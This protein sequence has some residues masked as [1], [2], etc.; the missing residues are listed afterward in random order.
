MILIITTFKH[1]NRLNEILWHFTTG[2]ELVRAGILPKLVGT[3]IYVP[4]MPE[5]FFPTSSESMKTI[6]AN[7]FSGCAT[8]SR[9]W[10]FFMHE[11][12]T[13]NRQLRLSWTD[14]ASGCNEIYSGTALVPYDT[15]VLVGFSLSKAK[16]RASIVMNDQ[17]VVDTQ[18]GIGNY[19]RQGR[20]MQIQQAALAD[21]VLSDSKKLLL[22]AHVLARPEEIAQAHGF[23][24]FMGDV[25]IFR[26]SPDGSTLVNLLSCSSQDAATGT[27]GADVLSGSA[28]TCGSQAAVSVMVQFQQGSESINSITGTRLQPHL[29]TRGTMGEGQP[30][31]VPIVAFA[32]KVLHPLLQKPPADSIVTLPGTTLD[33]N[34]CDSQKKSTIARG[35]E[36]LLRFSESDLAN[37]QA[38]ADAWASEVRAAMQFTWKGYRT[39]GWAWNF[40][41]KAWGHD[42]VMPASGRIKAPSVCPHGFQI[43]TGVMGGVLGNRGTRAITMLDGLSTLWVMGLEEEFNDAVE[44]LER[45][46]LPTADKHGQH[47]LFEINIRAFA[48]LLSAYSL[49]GKQVFLDTAKRLGEKLLKAFDTPSGMP[50]STIDIGTGEA[51][52]HSWNQNAVLAE[53]TTL[54]VEFRFITQVTGDRRW[55]GAAD[56]AMDVVLKAAGNRGLL[57]FEG[58]SPSGA[59]SQRLFR[60]I[61][62]GRFRHDSV[63]HALVNPQEILAR[64]P[65]AVTMEI[66]EN[67]WHI[68]GAVLTAILKICSLIAVG[69]HLERK[70][71]LN[72]EKRKC[73]SALAMDVCLPCLLFTD[74]LPEANFSL[75]MEGWQLLLWPFAYAS[76]SAL[77]GMLCCL[78]IGIPSQH[79]GAAAACAAFPNV[80]GFP[81]SVISALGSA[82]PK[83]PA[84][85]SPMV[86]L[87]IIQLTDGLLKYTLGPAVFRRDR[88]MRPS[89]SDLPL[90]GSL[91]S[92]E[93]DGSSRR[94]EAKDLDAAIEP[95]EQNCPNGALVAQKTTDFGLTMDQVH[96]VEPDWSRFDAY[97]V[98][99]GFDPTAADVSS[100]LREPFLKRV[101]VSHLLPSASDVKALLRQVVP[102]QV[103]AVLLALAIGMGPSEFKE[104]L[105]PPPG[106][107]GAYLGFVFGTAKE[108]GKGFVPLQMISLGGRMLN[109][110]S[111]H[112]PLA[113][114]GNTGTNTRSKLLRISAAVGVARMILAPMVL[115]FVAY[116]FNEYVLRP[117]DQIRPIAFW[118]PAFIVC[119]MPTANNMSTM[120]DL[121]GSG[122]SI[123]AATTAMQLMAAPVILVASLSTLLSLEEHLGNSS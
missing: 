61:T 58:F 25:R 110:V 114:S 45:A 81:V 116:A 76:V 66:S 111:D 119:A 6:A 78:A 98:F 105:V 50:L 34:P 84:G 74:V 115:Y 12:A 90:G 51:G 94:F 7:K 69:M 95:I 57:A 120:A 30:N 47:S 64:C 71:L 32:D 16:N 106:E 29:T 87:S 103:S 1:R 52:S 17:L 92:I 38:E 40:R 80:N 96:A 35:F 83:T 73:L 36:W 104:L 117:R 89:T 11:W 102:P 91:H 54:Q 2:T 10:A 46:N 70:K 55:Q 67:V 53:I 21:R 19:V 5:S 39:P 99:S 108:L 49:S 107:T 68:A 118:A 48:G 37:S 72:G 100:N 41:D 123:A 79:L 42:E 122:R 82:I 93:G 28:T 15:W 75:L 18:R 22:G 56:K 88:R 109:V 3:W 121:I 86:F 77:L 27:R 97:K 59:T 14:H 43:C 4:S 63:V 31:P 65:L 62:S 24:G 33:R 60:A 23:I 26:A 112:G 44:Y 20:M 101:Q 85:F 13:S 9:G 8:S 113:S